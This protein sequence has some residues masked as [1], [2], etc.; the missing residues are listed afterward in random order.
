MIYIVFI[1]RKRPIRTELSS[2]ICPMLLVFSHHL[3]TRRSGG[4]P[5]RRVVVN[6]TNASHEALRLTHPMCHAHVEFTSSIN[7]QDNVNDRARP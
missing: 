5:T 7:N 1:S 3:Q 2:R 6:P 4:E